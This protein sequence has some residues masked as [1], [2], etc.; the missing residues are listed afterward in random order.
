[1]RIDK[2]YIDSLPLTTKFPLK[3]T[4]KSK[5][6]EKKWKKTW[7]ID[8]NESAEGVYKFLQKKYEITGFNDVDTRRI[9]GLRFDMRKNNFSSTNPF[10]FISDVDINIISEIKENK[11][12]Y[13]CAAVKSKPMR[14]YPLGNSCA[15]MLGYVGII[16][17][18]EYAKFKNSGYGMQDN[19]GKA[20]LEKYLE[21][22]LKGTDGKTGVN[23][24]IKGENPVMNED[25][26]A[27]P[28]NRVML[29]IDLN[30]QRVAEQELSKA[31]SEIR[32]NKGGGIVGGGAAVA[33]DVKTGAVLSMASC[34]SYSPETFSKDYN[35]LINDKNNPLYNRTIVGTY[36]P[37]STFKPL[38][39]LAGLQEGVIT[40]SEKIECTGKYQYFAPNYTPSCWIY[41]YYGRKHG[42]VSVVQAIEVSCNIFFYETGRRLGISRINEYAKEFGFGKKTGIELSGESP[43]VV[44]G[45]EERE[46]SG[47][48]WYPA[49]TIQ[50]A[51]G[52]SD[53]KFT[54]LQL[55][56]YCE[57]LANKGVIYKPHIISSVIS[58]T[59]GEIIKNTQPQVLTKI[60][61]DDKYWNVVH[62]GMLAV[63]TEG[64]TA[65]IFKDAPYKVG[66]KTGT[67]QTS[68]SKNDS[69]FIAYAPYDDPKIA[70]ACIIENGGILG[71]GNKIVEVARKILDCYFAGSGTDGQALEYNK[72]T[73]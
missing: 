31:I 43:G 27:K 72:L 67:A 71:Q 69:L 58:G 59:T 40:P 24:D 15:H 73:E 3:F 41:G 62:Q 25:I 60:N 4:F 33:V 10:T 47:G 66:G 16:N 29:T 5:D 46:K 68:S 21:S 2:S 38:M 42:P 35:K 20:G 13:P 36:S 6:E 23:I 18:E 28:G 50:A 37:G 52:Q 8:E 51:I 70:V 53:N 1:T 34:P 45:P 56:D 19:V 65:K 26:P 9:L 44:A 14:D 12:L 7:K 48:D 54:I 64:S 39:A 30:M 57:G 63:T 61:I 11:K 32:S 22:D 17:E 55:A 49:D